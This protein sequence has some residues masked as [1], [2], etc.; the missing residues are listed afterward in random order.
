M[1][2]ATHPNDK[3]TELLQTGFPIAARTHMTLLL[4]TPPLPL[5]TDVDNIVRVGGTRV[6]LQTVISAFLNGATAEQIAQ[7]YPVLELAD[8]YAVIQ[9]YLRNRELVD[10]YLAERR[11]AGD[12]MQKQSESRCDPAGIRDRLLARR[13]TN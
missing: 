11:K 1:L 6:T 8:V 12:L 13:P 7:D 4:E 2:A 9:Y 3:I 5:E 10:E